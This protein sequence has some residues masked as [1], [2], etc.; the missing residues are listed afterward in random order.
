ML[1]SDAMVDYLLAVLVG[2]F[3]AFVAVPHHAKA[4]PKAP[5]LVIL[6]ATG[7]VHR[8]DGAMATGGNCILHDMNTSNSAESISVYNNGESPW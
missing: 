5:A 1:R 4:N 2:L 3:I 6:C 7:G 8:G